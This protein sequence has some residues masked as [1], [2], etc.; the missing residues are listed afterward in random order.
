VL[1]FFGDQRPVSAASKIRAENIVTNTRD[2]IS[3]MSN[4][5]RQIA[6]AFL[7][8]GAMLTF[9]TVS[10]YLTLNPNVYFPENAETY[11]QH[12]TALLL[13]VGGGMVAIFLGPFQF[14]GRLR[15][16][17]VTLHKAMG[18]IYAIGCVTG[19]GAGLAMATRAHGGFPSTAGFTMLAIMSLITI[20]FAVARIIRGDFAAH[21]EWMIRSFSL[22]LAAFTL[23]VILTTHGILEGTGVIE[24]PFTPVY[25]ATAWLCWVP[26]LLVAE[27]YINAS[28]TKQHPHGLPTKPAV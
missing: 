8:V 12:Q 22:T 21:R 26:N 7:F 15:Q 14:I 9:I 11:Q 18:C 10:R 19:A 25:Q 2:L 24:T 27:W 1:V 17:H 3:F 4:L 13:H 5:T 6:Q 16:R 23:R 28:R 20:T